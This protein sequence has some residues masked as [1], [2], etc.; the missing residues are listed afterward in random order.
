MQ[1]NLPKMSKPDNTSNLYSVD[2]DDDDDTFDKKYIVSGPTA[3]V[4]F[5][6]SGAMTTTHGY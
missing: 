5:K 6:H 4:K 3:P 1:V 2:L